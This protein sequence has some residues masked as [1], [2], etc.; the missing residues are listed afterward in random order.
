MVIDSAC[1][2]CQWVRGPYDETYETTHDGV[3]KVHR[4]PLDNRPGSIDGVVQSAIDAKHQQRNDGITTETNATKTPETALNV[5]P[6]SFNRVIQGETGS[7][8]EQQTNAIAIG[9]EAIS[10]E[11]AQQVT[12]VDSGGLERRQESEGPTLKAGSV[13]DTQV[14]LTTLDY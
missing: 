1:P 4:P 9:M 10:F 2:F 8:T 5:R 7:F 14:C 11:K 13:T 3:R 12:D 6:K